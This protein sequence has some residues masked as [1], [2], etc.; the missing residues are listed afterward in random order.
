MLT[1]MI[2][3]IPI[4][5]QAFED[6]LRGSQKSAAA[7]G[8][9]YLMDVHSRATLT[10]SAKITT[11][12]TARSGPQGPVRSEEFSTVGVFDVDWL[13]EPPFQRLLD[14]MAA[15]PMAFSGVRFFGSLN[16]GTREHI[17]PT[18]S[19]IVWPSLASPMDFSITFDALEALTSRGLVPFVVLSFFPAS[20][21]SSPTVPP[22]SFENWK[23]LIRGFLDQL[24]ADP[25]FGASA[26]RS[27]WFEVWNEPNIYAFW[28]GSFAQYL[29]LYRVTS[30]AV[31]ASGLDI[32]LGGPALAYQPV[33]GP[34][35][36]A[37]RMQTFLRF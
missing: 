1:D 15:S 6:R 27:W 33:E 20:V 35:A 9:E 24:A 29:D 36:P 30:E 31:M 32:K 11:H 12:A 2:A 4:A 8:P 25:R 10:D 5:R 17:D 18:D 34:N 21:S 3:T 37:Q 16:S 23:R 19:G 26:I 28:K 7:K 13:L 14:N 22:T